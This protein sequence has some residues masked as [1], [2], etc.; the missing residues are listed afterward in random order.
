[1]R[2]VLLTGHG[3]LE[4]IVA[5]DDLPVPEPGP[6]E[7]RVAVGACGVNNTDVWTR[8]G[9]YGTPT[10]P[11]AQ[12]GWQRR[13]LVFP[14]IQG[15]DVVGRIDAVGAG[16]AATRRGERVLVNPVLYGAEG[17]GLADHALLGSE[18][19]GGFAEH[20][21][22]PAANAHPVNTSL[23]DI[24][25]AAVPIAGLTAEH[26]LN[27]ARVGAGERVLVTGASGGVGSMAVQLARGRGAHVTA[28]TTAAKADRVRELGA[29]DVVHRDGD[30]PAWPIADVVIDVA[31]GAVF[32]LALG[33]LRHR[34][35]Y[36]TAGALAGA[37]VELDL[38]TLYL[39]ELE[40]IGATTGTRDE[41]AAVV[42]AVE[43]GHLRPVVAATYPLGDVARAQADLAQR[44]HVG[45]LVIETAR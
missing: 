10:D 30:R 40:L 19:D 6:D 24:E 22:V 42:A 2:G 12:A 23:G 44:D 38:R 32:A 3:G 1:M 11:T 25:L 20:V 13:P 5:R 26:M 4:R 15:G 37:L 21:V 35:R 36:V 34:G 41:F 18:R 8:E 43:A 31:G 28:V 7:V 9:A 33:A 14:R 17:D 27:R 29:D 39:D 16:V 45:N